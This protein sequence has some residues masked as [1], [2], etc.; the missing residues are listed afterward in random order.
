MGDCGLGN[1]KLGDDIIYTDP[2]T[3]AQRHDLLAGLVSQRFG[4]LNSI[5]GN[6][7]SFHIDIL[8]YVNIVIEVYLYVKPYKL[9]SYRKQHI[10]SLPT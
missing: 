10:M 5:N 1:I 2:F 7:N 6:Y 9:I 4:E 3:A 8:L